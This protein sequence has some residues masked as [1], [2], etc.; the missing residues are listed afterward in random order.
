MRSKTESPSRLTTIASPSSPHERT[1]RLS[2]AAAILGKRAVSGKQPD[3]SR[4]TPG[5]DAKAVVFDFVDPIWAG[6]RLYGGAR[7]TGGDKAGLRAGAVRHHA[8]ADK[9][10]WERRIS[11]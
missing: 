8:K 9:R 10:R 1:S 3:A 4:V 2:T 7:Q 6:E 5:E 11:P